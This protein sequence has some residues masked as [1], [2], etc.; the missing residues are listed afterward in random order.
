MAVVLVLKH[1]RARS[2]L[3]LA[4]L[5]SLTHDVRIGRL[6]DLLQLLFSI[7]IVFDG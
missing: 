6:D 5:S 3:Y 7:R 4:K 1:C 2:A